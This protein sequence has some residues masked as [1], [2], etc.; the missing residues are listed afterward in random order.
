MCLCV[1]REGVR[2]FVCVCVC[3]IQSPV[4]VC[5]LHKTHHTHIHTQVLALGKAQEVLDAKLAAFRAYSEQALAASDKSQTNIS[6]NRVF[7][8]A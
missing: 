3:A 4:N 2:V 8:C 1:C 7:F 6:S 5:A